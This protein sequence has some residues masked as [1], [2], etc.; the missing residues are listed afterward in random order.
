MKYKLITFD[1]DD[2]FWNIAPVIIKAEKD[3]RA[4]LRKTVG[5]IEWGSMSDFMGIREDL[6]KVMPSLE[7]DIGLLR[8][9]IYKQKLKNIVPNES[10]RNELIN[11]AYSMF[12][13]KRHEVI[14][15]DG[16]YDAI[17]KLSK[18]YY[19]GILTN[20]NA[21]IF[22]YD[23]GRFFDFSISSFDVQDNKPNKPHFESAKNKYENISYEEII[24][25]GDHQINDVYGAYQLGMKAIW[26]NDMN[27]EW[28]QSFDK[29]DEF[30]HWNDCTKL[31]E[32]IDER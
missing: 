23:I 29:P 2:T 16:V 26:F 7:W 31:I 30:S 28:D 24:H 6:I 13:E 1:L 19:L 21:D 12:L 14:F 27:N 11:T 15:Y 32:E 20:G 8:K 18:K 9:E 3:T 22:K 5:E 25:I 4:W 17:E 10:E